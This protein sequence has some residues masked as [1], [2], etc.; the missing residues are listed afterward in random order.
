MDFFSRLLWGHLLLHHVSLSSAQMSALVLTWGQ[1]LGWPWVLASSTLFDP[2][3]NPLY[4]NL[5][6]PGRVAEIL[7]MNFLS[8]LLS[9]D[10]FKGNIVCACFLFLYTYL[11]KN[12]SECKS[13][14]ILVPISSLVTF[15]KRWGGGM[16]NITREVN[17][18][19]DL[20]VG[21]NLTHQ[22]E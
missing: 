22:R 17:D 20:T 9:I 21:I 19:A 1:T 10:A 13:R 18:E 15:L 8:I 14:N 7:T 16:Q 4:E 6:T 5:K 3:V 12:A 2:N 11:E